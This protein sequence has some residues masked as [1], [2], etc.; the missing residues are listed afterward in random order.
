MGDYDDRDTG[1]KPEQKFFNRFRTSWI[2]GAGGFIHED[3]LRL[4]S[5]RTGQTKTLLLS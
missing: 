2:E 1:F 4:H 5:E 3:D